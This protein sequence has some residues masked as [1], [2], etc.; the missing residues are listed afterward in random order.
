M[1]TIN[2]IIYNLEH[3]PSDINEHISTL[4]KYAS[5]CSHITEMGVR[6]FGSTWAFIKGNPKKLICYDISHPS[7]FGGN[8]NEVSEIS[9]INNVNFSFIQADTTKIQIE[10]TELLFIDT[11]HSYKQLKTELYLHAN[12]TSKYIIMHD[13]TTFGNGGGGDGDIIGLWPA[14]QEFIDS[15]PEWQMIER[16]TNNNG[17]TVLKRV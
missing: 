2:E 14:I 12:K 4:I 16:R 13:T 1:K 10:P 6:A 5:K 9:K 15:H 3:N 17:L 8:I 7:E 11:L